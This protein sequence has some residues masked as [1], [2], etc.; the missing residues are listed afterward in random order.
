VLAERLRAAVQHALTGEETVTVS[1]GYACQTTGRFESAVQL[2]EAADAALYS[3]KEQGRNTIAAF[4]GRRS[5]DPP[6]VKEDET[7]DVPRAG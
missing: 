6:S 5:N 3:A 7:I 4:Q 2:F 1:I